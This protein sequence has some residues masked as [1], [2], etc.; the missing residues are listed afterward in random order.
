M[1]IYELE[2]GEKKRIIVNKEIVPPAQLAL[3]VNFQ[4]NTH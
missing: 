1:N 4:V 2:L 3:V